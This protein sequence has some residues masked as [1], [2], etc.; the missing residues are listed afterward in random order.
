MP[1]GEYGYIFKLDLKSIKSFSRLE[2]LFGENLFS[3]EF[4]LSYSLDDVNLVELKHVYRN[5]AKK[6]NI[7]FNTVRGRYVYFKAIKPNLPNEKGDQMGIRRLS[8]YYI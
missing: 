8:V 7:N 3:T 1:T 2:V 5:E 6:I 4:T